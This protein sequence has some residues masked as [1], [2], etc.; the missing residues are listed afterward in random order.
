M[1]RQDSLNN[2][3]KTEEHKKVN[4]SVKT[5]FFTHKNICLITYLSNS[6]ENLSHK[7]QKEEIVHLCNSDTPPTGRK[8]IIH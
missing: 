6:A 5:L 8:S 2:K 3:I 1:Y 4:D 7:K